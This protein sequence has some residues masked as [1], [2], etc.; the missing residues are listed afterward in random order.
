MKLG[1]AEG[2]LDSGF[3]RPKT[4]PILLKNQ[5]ERYTTSGTGAYLFV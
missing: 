1:T 4:L 3:L 2:A 5:F